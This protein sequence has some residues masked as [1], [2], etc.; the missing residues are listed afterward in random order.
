MQINVMPTTVVC[1]TGH[2]GVVPVGELLRVES[3][4]CLVMADNP[5][6]QA[7]LLLMSLHSLSHTDPVTV[8]SASKNRV[9]TSGYHNTQIQQQSQ[10]YGVCG[11][12]LQLSQHLVLGLLVDEPSFVVINYT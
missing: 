12:T 1:P 2:S 3:V 11:C 7:W 10:E 8:A 9:R 5:C 6:Y 4:Y